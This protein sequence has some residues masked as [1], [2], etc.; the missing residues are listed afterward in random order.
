MAA[1]AAEL[2]PE[3]TGALAREVARSLSSTAEFG[4]ELA[5]LPWSVL[6]PLTFRV[7]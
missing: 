5:A 2:F 6:A 4:A 1:T 3:G 7:L